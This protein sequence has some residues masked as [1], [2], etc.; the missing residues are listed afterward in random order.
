MSTSEPTRARLLRGAVAGL[1]AGMVASFAMDQFQQLSA[2]LSASGDDDD[3]E[4][5]TAK[6]ADALTKVVTGRPVAKSQQAAAGQTVHYAVGAALGVAYGMAAEFSPQVA[7][8]YG[9]M[10]SLGV[11]ALLDE[12]AVPAAGLGP[13]PWDTNIGTH[14]YALT[15]HLV[16]G[17][18]AEFTRRRVSATMAAAS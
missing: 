3:S 16:F 9:S 8:G 14:A 2:R 7:K 4:P 17:A 18:V 11:T 1:V 13:P 5:A 6:A 10:F 15:S 12:T